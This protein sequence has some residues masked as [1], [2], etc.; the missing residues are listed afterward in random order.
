MR[1]VIV[2]Y[3]THNYGH[4]IAYRKFRGVWW[5]IS[6]E[7]V[8][9]V[10]EAEVLSTPGVFMLFYEYDYDE[11]TGR[12]KDDIEYEFQLHNA[13]NGGN[14]NDTEENLDQSELEKESD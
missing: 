5:R 3:G 13:E 12:M 14:K 7:S 2:H 11:K 4:Y 8:Y 1:S 10:D 6:D 9:V